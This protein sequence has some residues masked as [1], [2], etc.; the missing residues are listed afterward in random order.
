MRL[1][2]GAAVA[3]LALAGCERTPPSEQL[4]V[5]ALPDE[6]SVETIEAADLAA[7]IEAGEAI[8][9]D[10]RTPE[11]FAAGRLPGALNAPVETFDPAAIPM[12]DGRETILYCRSGKRSARAA[13]MLAKHTGA[14]VRHL[15]GGIE[16][17]TAPEPSQRVLIGGE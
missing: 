10:V 2:A 14:R 13:E 7:L 5:K 8:V 16:A 11:E 4:D 6:G 9:I 12:E 15:E 3:A 1:L 17:W